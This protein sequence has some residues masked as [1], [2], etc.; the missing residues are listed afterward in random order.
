MRAKRTFALRNKAERIKLVDSKSILQYWTSWADD[1]HD[2]I[3]TLRQAPDLTMTREQLILTLHTETE[4]KPIQE[5]A[6]RTSQILYQ[7][8][9]LGFIEAA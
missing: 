8:K 9:K 3:D 7:L 2:V 6:T 4:L 1:Y 5:F